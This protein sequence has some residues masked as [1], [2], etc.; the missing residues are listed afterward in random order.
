LSATPFFSLSYSNPNPAS[1]GNIT[2][3]VKLLST[4]GKTR[5]L[6]SPLLMVLNNQTAVLKVTDNIVYFTIKADTNSN[7]NTSTT[8][9]TTTQNVVPV[10][11]IMNLTAQISD[12]D[13]VTLNVRPTIT[14]VVKYIQD[15]NP[16][17]RATLTQPAI[18]SL[19][20]ET[21]TREMES[22]L[23]VA[24][25]QTAILGG[26]ME[27]SFEG[28]RDGLPNASRIPIVG[29]FFSYRND[30]AVK[31]ELVILL[32]PLVVR[33]ASIEGDL[34]AFRR[35]V[36]DN[37][38]FKDTQSPVPEFQEA[39]GRIERGEFPQTTPNPMVPDLPV[40]AASSQGM[41]R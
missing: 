19:I 23:R 3:T 16:A 2:S 27:D 28:T 31:K 32:R 13:V 29:D 39:M 24:S 34:S 35:F 37:E 22:V 12:N 40:P 17:L 15:P 1:G 33:N 41:P 38:F 6:S 21:R 14:S 7:A 10:G 8:T 20:P 18:S 36:P 5:V 4:F 30:K 9:F 25:G 26:L 11:F